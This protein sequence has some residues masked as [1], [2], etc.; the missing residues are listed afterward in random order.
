MKYL[1]TYISKL[2]PRG[3]WFFT[4][5]EALAALGITPGQFRF[6]AYRLSK[7][8][9]LKRLIGSFYMIIPPQYTNRGSLPPDWI[10]APLMEHLK[11]DYYIGL[12]SAGSIYG[13]TEQQPMIFQVITNKQS[14]PI[15][16]ERGNIEFHIFK[17]C[18][19]AVTKEIAVSTGFVKISTREQLW[20][21]WF[22]FIDPV[23]TLAMSLW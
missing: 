6:Q 21:I 18:S 19:S 5:E 17:E 14:K 7:K 8:K 22:V 10:V 3:K 2:L 13:A 20:L 23:A 12:L 11:Q 9:L 16:L 4:K 1:R 15:E